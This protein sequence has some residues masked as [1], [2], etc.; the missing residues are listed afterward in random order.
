[1]SGKD[2]TK[3]FNDWYKGQGY[4]S[5]NVQWTQLGNSHVRIKMNQTVSHP[6]VSFFALPVA[7]KFKNATQ[8]KT[9]VV[10]NKFNGELVIKNIGFVADTVFIDPDAWLVTRNNSSQ[11]VPDVVTGQNVLLV[12]PNPFS[13]RFYV[14]LRNF[15]AST[16]YINLF[17]STGQLVA[18]QKVSLLNG[19]EF[20]EMV[21]E[22]LA[23]G[24]YVVRVEADNGFKNSKQVLKMH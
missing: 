10:D 6:S 1:V 18:S 8:E 22:K 15:S 7:L 24:I 9:I 16:A 12:Y 17:N 13:D 5:Y 14:Y 20:V 3:F 2:L 11:K 19:S 23:S 21:S 4:P